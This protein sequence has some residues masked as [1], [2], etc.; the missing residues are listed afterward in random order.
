MK[1]NPVLQ[2]KK[3]YYNSLSVHQIFPLLFYHT[4]CKCGLQY[5]LEKMFESSHQDTYFSMTHYN[6]GC[7]HCFENKNAFREHVKNNIMIPESEWEFNGEPVN[8]I[9]KAYLSHLSK[10]NNV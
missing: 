4:C 8:P 6:T 2:D 3:D 7:K 10:T 9:Q 1:R 5:K